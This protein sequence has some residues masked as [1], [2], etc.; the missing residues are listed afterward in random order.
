[1]IDSKTKKTVEELRDRIAAQYPI[2][3]IKLFGSSA[4]G[5]THRESD[6]DVWV[7]LAELNR[8]IEEDLFSIAY[9]VELK[10]DCLI[11][12]VAV[13][14]KD[15]FGKIGIAPIQKNILSE[16]IAI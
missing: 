11:D 12:L 15:L 14:E 6:I 2:Q 8:K 9:D 13:S 4:R 5:N 16:G 3:Q 7:C 10:Y 1:M